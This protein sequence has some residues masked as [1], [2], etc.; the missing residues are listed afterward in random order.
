MLE[1]KPYKVRQELK[2]TM[3]YGYQQTFRTFMPA[4]R[5]PRACRFRSSVTI[6]IGFNPAFSAS[7]VGITSNASAYA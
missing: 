1:I 6:A 2:K 3:V 5:S 7:V 4:F